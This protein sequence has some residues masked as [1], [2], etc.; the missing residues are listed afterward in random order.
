MTALN[1]S[2]L[3]RAEL[4][5]IITTL[6][7]FL[8]NGAQIFETAVLVPKWSSNPPESLIVLKPPYGPDLKTF[9]IVLHSIHE[10]TFLIAIAFCWKLSFLRDEL[11][12]LFILHFAV[13]VWTIVYFAP[14]IIAF[15]KTDDTRIGIGSLPK[16][17]QKW[18]RLNYLRVGIFI[19]ISC[20]L[21][22]LCFQL[23]HM[24]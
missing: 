19:A 7:Y 1:A 17:T 12:V 5:L 18:R 16:L 3:E 20:V 8:M 2:Y 24:R 15:Q 21:V 9:W 10:T 14:N 22:Q 23:I 6:I 11:L 4:W 13:R